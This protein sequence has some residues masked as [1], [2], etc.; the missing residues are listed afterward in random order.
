MPMWV[1]KRGSHIPRAYLMIC[2]FLLITS[3]VLLASS[4]RSTNLLNRIS[5][6]RSRS[7]KQVAREDYHFDVPTGLRRSVSEGD[8]SAN[9]EDIHYNLCSK[10]CVESDVPNY[11]R[12]LVHTP[13]S[14]SKNPPACIILK[15]WWKPPSKQSIK[16]QE[17][18]SSDYIFQ[19]AK[20]NHY[21]AV[22]M[23]TYAINQSNEELFV[24]AVQACNDDILTIS[25]IH[26]YAFL[27]GNFSLNA[28]LS[29]GLILE[30]ML[31]LISNK[32]STL[33]SRLVERPLFKETIFR[34]GSEL[35]HRMLYTN[36]LFE[37]ADFYGQDFFDLFHK[38]IRDYLR[39]SKDLSLSFQLLFKQSKASSDIIKRS[40][41]NLCLDQKDSLL[42]ELPV[43]TN[44]LMSSLLKEPIYRQ[45]VFDAMD[46]EEFKG[47]DV[48]SFPAE[49]L[50]FLSLQPP[51]A[52]SI[53][54]LY[55]PYARAIQ[56]CVD[57]PHT[58]LLIILEYIDVEEEGGPYL[59]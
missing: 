33:M 39:F 14:V 11:D 8:V 57:F 16:Y 43:F 22:V 54:R 48:S 46:K 58:H 50:T 56:D 41:I 55:R 19:L 13:A 31:R 36:T 1:D 35:V 18:H 4:P 12:F 34:Y 32:N 28:L 5:L 17:L 6:R 2:P 9:A 45:L 49:V 3:T 10:S 44:S 26:G 27:H 53:R 59:L 40:L 23:G 15:P 51:K 20:N 25:Y 30:T 29:P 47:I 21:E 52:I 42:L 24:S 38:I 37:A 7:L